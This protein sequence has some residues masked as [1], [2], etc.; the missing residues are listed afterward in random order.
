MSCHHPQPYLVPAKGGKPR[1]LPDPSKNIRWKKGLNPYLLGKVV[2]LPCGNCIACRREKRQDYTILQCCEASLYDPSENWF[3]TLT[4]DDEKLLDPSCTSSGAG[5]PAYSLHKDDLQHF[6]ELLRHR[7]KSLGY[8]CRVFGCGEYGEQFERPHYHLSLFGLPASV[9]GVT[10]Y[11]RD[12]CTSNSEFSNYGRLSYRSSIQS[13]SSGDNIAWQSDLVADLW[14][15]GNHQLYNACRETFQYVAGYVVKKLTGLMAT[16]KWDV[17]NRQ[18]PF[19][20]QSRPSIGRPWFD[21]FKDSLSNPFGDKLVNDVVSLSGIQWKCP[22]IFEKWTASL[23]HF[24]GPAIVE[25]LKN[26]RTIDSPDFP[27][28]VEVKRKKDFDEY[29]ARHYQQNNN[30]K[31]VQ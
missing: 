8:P 19:L 27:D 25:R 13:V 24:D 12:I 28:L 3:L 20:I 10:N 30:H 17:T 7:L 31:E 15:F 6:M 9:L 14:P 16:E 22:R 1:R 26:I 29:S 21:K 4:Y 23:D 11:D 18:R 5:I 2:Y